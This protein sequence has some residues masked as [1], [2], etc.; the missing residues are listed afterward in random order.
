MNQ[1]F[2]EYFVCPHCQSPQTLKNEL[3]E[4]IDAGERYCGVC[5]KEIANALTEA[6]AKT[7]E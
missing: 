2:K 5:G 1:H 4:H 7:G 3:K 6:L